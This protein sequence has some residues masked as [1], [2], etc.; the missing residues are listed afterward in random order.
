MSQTQASE[1]AKSERVTLTNNSIVE[2][3]IDL[4]QIDE[5]V[6]AHDGEH[7][8]SATMGKET[9][10]AIFKMNGIQLPISDVEFLG[11]AAFNAANIMIVTTETFT[12]RAKE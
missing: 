7:I 4:N 1:S 6:F 9:L 2:E 10:G 11:L 5:V 3:E 12:H 8:G